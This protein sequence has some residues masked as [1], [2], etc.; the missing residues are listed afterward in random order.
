MKKKI[1]IM[2]VVLVLIALA[3]VV[4]LNINNGR[5]LP[6]IENVNI[7]GD[8]NIVTSLEDKINGDSA[9][10]GTFNL[11]WNDLKNDLAKQDIIFE[12]QTEIIDNLNKGTFTT[13]NLSVESYYKKY[14]TPTLEL[15]EEI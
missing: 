13:A 11:I 7:S 6:L 8:I 3:I 4:G 10:C 15:K 14:G 9:W 2:I 12:N 5:D 1:L